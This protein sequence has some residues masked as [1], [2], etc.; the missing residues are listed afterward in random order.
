MALTLALASVK[1][2]P[3]PLPNRPASMNEFAMNKIKN[4]TNQMVNYEPVLC[5]IAFGAMAI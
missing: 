2:N 5:Y 3:K 1:M 4:K